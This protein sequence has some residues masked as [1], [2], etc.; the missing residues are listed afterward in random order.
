[1]ADDDS[2]NPRPIGSTAGLDRLVV[3]ES[4]ESI[5]LRTPFEVD[6][7]VCICGHQ[8]FFIGIAEDGKACPFCASLIVARCL[9]PKCAT[10][11]CLG[12]LQ[13]A[14]VAERESRRVS[15]LADAGRLFS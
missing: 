7:A 15:L 8:A 6:G 1:M 12:C 11:A 14:A 10:W 2:K 4:G 5:R 3:P 9:R 13:K